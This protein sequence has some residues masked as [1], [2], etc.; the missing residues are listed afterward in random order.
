MFGTDYPVALT[1]PEIDRILAIDLTEKE[2]KDI[3]Y[4]NAARFLHLNER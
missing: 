4:N 1:K 2:R 3:F